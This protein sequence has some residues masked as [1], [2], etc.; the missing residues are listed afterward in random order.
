MEEG[1]VEASFVPVMLIRASTLLGRQVRAVS[2]LSGGDL[3][4]VFRLDLGNGDTAIAKQA[5]DVAIEARMLRHL[6][7]RNVPV[8]GVIAQDGDL[9]IME[10]LPSSSSGVRS[11]AELAEILDSLHGRS[12][13]HYG[14]EEDYAFG[15]VAICNRPASSWVI[16]WA[17]QRLRCHLPYVGFVVGERISALCDRLGVLI[18]DKPVPSLLHGDLWS[19]NILFNGDQVAGLIDPA[20]YYGDREVDCA[21]LG[22]FDNPQAAFFEACGLEAGWEQRQPVYRLWPLLVHLRLFGD[23]YARQVGTCLGELG[24]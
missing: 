9:L 1:R 14:W 13:N 3:S 10:D 4:T 7:L 8:P 24:F 2:R 23:A 5:P 11:W 12:G 17:D 6:A 22:L 21:M 15:S 18:P 16:F 19:G 20:C